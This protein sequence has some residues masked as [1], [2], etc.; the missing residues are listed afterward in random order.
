MLKT[1]SIGGVHPQDNK[2]SAHQPIV[3]AQIP[4]QAVIMLNQHI[5]APAKP[6]VAKGD[7][8]KVGTRIGEPSGHVSAAIHSSVSGI[9]AKVDSVPD[10][11]GYAHP[12]VFINVE[13]DEWEDTIDRSETLVSACSLSAEEIIRKITDA[14]IVGL[15]GACFPTHVKL[16]PSPTEKVECII[17]NA[18]ECEP[19]LTAD[20]QL[21]LEH[22]EEIMVGISILMKAV[23][24]NKAFVGI[25][26]NK[27]DA[28]RQMSKYASTYTGIE[29]VPLKIKYPEGGEKQ[30]IE[31]ITGK[32]VPVGALPISV[33]TIVQNVATVYAIYQAVQKNRP[34]FER[35]VCVTGKSLEKPSNML[36]RIGTPA[37]QLI[38]ACGGLPEGVS[39]VISGGPMMGKAL[40]N[41]DIPTTKGMSGILVLTRKEAKRG[42]VQ[43]CIRCAKCVAVCPM[44]LEPYL[45]STASAHGCFEK[46]E[47]EG[48]MSCIECGSCQFTCPSNRPILDFVRLGKMKVKDMIRA[49]QVNK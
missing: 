23:K 49:R 32:K 1:F 22:A 11:S 12:A 6:V 7:R 16:C 26:N 39:Q 24:V 44:G 19:Y 41:V 4:S 45:L 36:V 38:E 33:G 47:K 14:G 35:V 10:A 20:H 40:G 31:A 15:G 17:V 48:I 34:L 43:P 8:V 42:N 25:E 2:L 13:G 46:V 9:V 37:I 29:V 5:G 28:I 27:P 21:M 18:V 30:L 3:R